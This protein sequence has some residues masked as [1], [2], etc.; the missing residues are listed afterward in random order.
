MNRKPD[1]FV[2]GAPR[3]GT[4]AMCQ[5]LAEH[6]KI[7][8][9]DPKEPFYF[10]RDFSTRITF[11]EAAYLN[12]FRDAGPEHEAVGEGSPY[13]LFSETAVAE[14]LEFQ[15]GARFVVMLRNPVEMV[16]SF[17]AQL[18]VAGQEDVTD[19]SEAW[20]LQE[21]RAKGESLP[22][23]NR[24]PEFLQYRKWGLF[25]EQLLRLFK[26]VDHDRLCV[27]I[28][29]DFAEDAKREYE[30]ILKFL[31]VESDGRT[32]FPRV[33]GNRQVVAGKSHKLVTWFLERA[34]DLREKLG[35]RNAKFGILK[36]IRNLSEKL[37]F[38]KGKRAQ[39]PEELNAELRNC[40]REDVE[41]L[42][43]ILDRDLTHWTQLPMQ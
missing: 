24:W 18:L 34:I 15:S 33:L 9:A 6:P 11:D 13:G 19:F 10:G 3:C 29:E 4:T 1:F 26:T 43:R 35:M 41:K 21:T 23:A 42:S 27:V 40:F 20:S 32:E 2:I 5:Y 8:F 7:A 39:L 31:N 37:S 16:Q 12:C 36:R 17:H 14:I 22:R 28:Y 30:Q 25:G 38:R